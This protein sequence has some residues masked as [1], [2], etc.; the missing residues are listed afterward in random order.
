[1]SP[2][3]S[4]TFKRAH[5]R[6]TTFL[7]ESDNWDGFGAKP[8]SA[9][10]G[11]AVTAFLLNLEAQGIREPG[12]AM[13]ADGTVAV[14]WIS[15][16]YY[17]TADFCDADGYTFVATVDQKTVSMGHCATTDL[18]PEL[19]STLNQHCRTKASPSEHRP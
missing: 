11:E 8:A 17:I 16:D 4:T 14:V 3:T 1:M 15:D 6:L 19:Q 13:G 10:V 9:V 12:L 7:N 5:A 18:A 2:K